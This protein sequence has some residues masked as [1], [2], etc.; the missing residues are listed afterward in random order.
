MNNDHMG[1]YRVNHDAAMWTDITAQLQIVPQVKLL[2]RLPPRRTSG[3]SDSV[4]AVIDVGFLQLQRSNVA[5]QISTE[6]IHHLVALT[7]NI[8]ATLDSF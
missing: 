3:S 8:S 7:E 4:N 6:S 5:P 2:L 1:F